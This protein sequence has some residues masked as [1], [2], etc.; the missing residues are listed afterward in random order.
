MIKNINKN[1]EL[2]INLVDAIF[3]EN[4]KSITGINNKGEKETK[5]REESGKKREDRQ[6]LLHSLVHTMKKPSNP[7]H[8]CI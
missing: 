7:A 3:S 6:T 5:M 4:D 1:V 8:V 2:N